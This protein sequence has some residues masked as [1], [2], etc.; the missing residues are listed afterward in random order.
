EG[1]CRCKVRS[2]HRPTLG[3]GVGDTFDSH[4]NGGTAGNGYVVARRRASVHES[5]REQPRSRAIRIDIETQ[6]VPIVLL[7][8]NALLLIL[9]RNRGIVLHLDVK[10]GVRDWLHD[11]NGLI[12]HGPNIMVGAAWN[13][14]AGVGTIHLEK[15][16][17]RRNERPKRGIERYS[18]EV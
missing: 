7:N 6:E 14:Q 12:S 18:M 17:A 4:P 9:L 11:T 1:C 15:T 2:I 16:T 13:N 5:S 3:P 10:I 8:N